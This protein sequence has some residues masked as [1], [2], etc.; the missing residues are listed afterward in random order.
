[1]RSTRPTMRCSAIRITEAYRG[2]STAEARCRFYAFGKRV[3]AQGRHLDV[4]GVEG[5]GFFLRIFLVLP[6][7][8]G[9]DHAFAA[10]AQRLE[11]FLRMIC[12]VMSAES[13][14]RIMPCPVNEGGAELF[15]FSQLPAVADLQA[16]FGYAFEQ[17]GF[18]PYRPAASEA[19]PVSRPA[20]RYGGCTGG[21][22]VLISRIFFG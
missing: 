10:V 22:S 19:D 11:F 15:R 3:A 17:T 8:A 7:L 9:H 18:F 16:A 21:G 1:M 13:K 12:R 4:F 2:K 20:Q 6:V 14:A 5:E